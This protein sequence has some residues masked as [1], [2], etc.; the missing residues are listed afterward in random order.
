MSHRFRTPSG[1]KGQGLPTSHSNTAKP[2]RNAHSR[3]PISTS[4]ILPSVTICRNR[5]TA[6]APKGSH[7]NDPFG[8]FATWRFSGKSSHCGRA[9]YRSPR[10]PFERLSPHAF[11]IF[12]TSRYHLFQHRFQYV[13]HFLSP[14]RRSIPRAVETLAFVAWFKPGS[15]RERSRHLDGRDR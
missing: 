6:E 12:S 14:R 3:I 13:F 4:A 15:Q 8:V 1:V 7:G 2:T 11:A 10:F 5:Q 9:K